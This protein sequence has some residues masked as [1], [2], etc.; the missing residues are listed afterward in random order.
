MNTGR[1]TLEKI[2]PGRVVLFGLQVQLQGP[3]ICPAVLQKQ[4]GNR[5]GD[6]PVRATVPAGCPAISLQGREIDSHVVFGQ[7]VAVHIDDDVIVDGMVD[8]TRFKPVSRLG[9][10]EYS[11][12]AEV[13]SMN[14]PGGTD[15]GMGPESLTG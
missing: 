3:L 11:A 2:L 13:F 8:V 15:A 7:V 4:L 10:R 1:D 5:V 6:G 12:V 14:R 9:Y